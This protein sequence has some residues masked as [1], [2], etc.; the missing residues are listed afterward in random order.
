[1]NILMPIN[2]LSIN[3]LGI[4]HVFLS[5][6][7]TH[8]LSMTNSARPFPSHQ[9]SSS[10]YGDPMKGKGEAKRKPFGF[11]SRPSSIHP[12]YLDNIA[13]HPASVSKRVQNL[14]HYIPNRLSFSPCSIEEA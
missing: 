2:H 6:Q 8:S 5:R 12:I 10:P 9:I 14:V 1:M 4:C 7:I 13:F 11:S 3:G